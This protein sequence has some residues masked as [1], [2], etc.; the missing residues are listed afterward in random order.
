MII[1]SKFGRT[2]PINMTEPVNFVQVLSCEDNVTPIAEV[3][4]GA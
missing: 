3:G 2:H 1:E 4:G